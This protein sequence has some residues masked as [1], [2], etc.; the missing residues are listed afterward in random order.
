MSLKSSR[1]QKAVNSSLLVLRLESLKIISVAEAD[2]FVIIKKEEHKAD[3]VIDHLI[4]NFFC[5]CFFAFEQSVFERNRVAAVGKLSDDHICEQG[6][7][8]GPCFV[9][10]SI[11]QSGFLCI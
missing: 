1:A 10:Q 11:G 5:R 3:G 4:I 8:I 2:I 7:C 6:F 9:K